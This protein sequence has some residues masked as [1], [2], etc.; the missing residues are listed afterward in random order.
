MCYL[1][2]TYLKSDHEYKEQNTMQNNSEYYNMK[3]LDDVE[4]SA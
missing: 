2:K 3:E 1:I 4:A